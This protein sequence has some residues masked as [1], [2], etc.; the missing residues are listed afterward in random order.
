[1]E[2]EG[3]PFKSEA[4]TGNLPLTLG[5]SYA[6]MVRH[7][8]RPI[9]AQERKGSFTTFLKAPVSLAMLREG[10]HKEG[11]SDCE[12]RSLGTK[13]VLLITIDNGQM[14]KI[15]TDNEMV[16][17]QWFG[18]LCLGRS[19][20]LESAEKYGFLVLVFHYIS[21]MKNFFS[22]LAK[23][24]GTL[25][26]IDS[27][28]SQQKRFDF[29]RFVIQTQNPEV[30]HAKVAIKVDEDYFFIIVNEESVQ[31]AD[32]RGDYELGLGGKA[33]VASFSTISM[34]RVPNSLGPHI[35]GDH[36][37]GLGSPPSI[38]V[39]NSKCKLGK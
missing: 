13:T 7:L 10:L 32:R 6:D 9:Q 1:M 19:R 39:K 24:W 37:P 38:V 26:A 31:D 29:T 3:R 5:V 22:S 34:S 16:F 27:E 17:A 18:K 15:V 23:R 35:V 4:G 30:I 2:G 36:F 20:T 8:P 21:G 11:I 28:T 25:T 33:N 14:D 12:V